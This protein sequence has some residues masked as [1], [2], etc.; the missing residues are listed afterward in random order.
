[1][2]SNVPDIATVQKLKNTVNTTQNALKHTKSKTAISFLG[3]EHSFLPRLTLSGEREDAPFSTTHHL[4]AFR[5]SIPSVVHHT[6]RSGD[7]FQT[8]YQGLN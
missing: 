7:V 6:F 2:S 4:V 1:M 5:Y 3:T 8:F